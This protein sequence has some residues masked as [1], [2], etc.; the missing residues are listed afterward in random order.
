MEE[1]EALCTRL[2]IMVNGEFKCL[3]SPQHLKAK[4]G[5][6]YKL[7]IRL[8]D[9]KNKEKLFEFIKEKFVASVNTET[10]KNLYEFILPFNSTKL[11]QIFGII[12]KNRG[13]LDLLD[14][15]LTQTTLDQIFVN[16]AKSQKED[17]FEDEETQANGATSGDFQMS[18]V[19]PNKIESKE[20]VEENKLNP[21]SN[22]D[23]ENTEAEKMSID[24]SDDEIVV[25]VLS[26]TLN[27]D[28]EHLQESGFGK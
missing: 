8:N 5:Y 1:C 24:E 27:L 15:S 20:I 12:E 19:E 11:S 18:R 26:K 14:Y 22:R 10:H 25:E 7:M 23:D 6:G 28:D 4:F 9:E 2:V 17:A 21:E 16:F 3:G 13:T